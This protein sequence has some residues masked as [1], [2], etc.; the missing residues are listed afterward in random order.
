MD[1]AFQVEQDEVV[2]R[3]AVWVGVRA[4]V[5][6]EKQTDS[7][8]QVGPRNSRMIPCSAATASSS[9]CR[10]GAGSPSSNHMRTVASPLDSDMRMRS[11]SL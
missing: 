5:L 6:W 1:A 4:A 2:P 7:G 10:D 3:S 11:A 9:A 8:C